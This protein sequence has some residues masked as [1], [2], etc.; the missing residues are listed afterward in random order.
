MEIT[1]E[2][3]GSAVGDA[4][5]AGI[6]SERER[7]AKKLRG[8]ICFDHDRKGCDHSACY[9]L[10]DILTAMVPNECELCDG[11]RV[12]D[13]GDVHGVATVRKCDACG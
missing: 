2:V 5:R 12:I 7:W 11:D 6:E 4:C 9:T 13:E 8:L 3:F 10:E 1:S